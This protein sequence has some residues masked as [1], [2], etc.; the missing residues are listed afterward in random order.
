MISYN[1]KTLD[2]LD[3]LDEAE[4]A[5][6]KQC[7]TVEE[8]NQIK[9]AYP[10]DLYTPNFYVRIGLFILTIIV[11]TFAGG[12]FGLLSSGGGEKTFAV[13]CII[14]GLA[15]VAGIEFMIREK[16]HHKSGVDT[17]LMWM[18]GCSF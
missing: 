4:K 12:F 7:I 14:F 2:N 6:R 13:L 8:F 1:S 16:K 5:A 17:A 18:S 10:V 9:K 11:V 3:L 15:L